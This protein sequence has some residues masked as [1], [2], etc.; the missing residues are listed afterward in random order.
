MIEI[1]NIS[2]VRRIAKNNSDRE[3]EKRQAHERLYYEIKE[4]VSDYLCEFYSKKINKFLNNGKP[5]YID[6]PITEYKDVIFNQFGFS[7]HPS[8]CR[9]MMDTATNKLIEKYRAVGYS[10][11]RSVG[12]SYEYIFSIQVRF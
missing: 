9:N 5:A 7:G 3:E 11:C 1:P 2:K 4:K 10:A 12:D 6:I 8:E